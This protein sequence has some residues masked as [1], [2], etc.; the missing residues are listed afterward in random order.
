[1]RVRAC[2]SMSFTLS[3]L[4]VLAG[5]SGFMMLSLRR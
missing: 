5:V 2:C 4:F 1:M 3:K